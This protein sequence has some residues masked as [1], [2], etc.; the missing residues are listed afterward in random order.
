MLGSL[1]LPVL[2]CGFPRVLAPSLPG[3]RGSAIAKPIMNISFLSHPVRLHS[4]Y[5]Q[6][7]FLGRKTQDIVYIFF[8]HIEYCFA[9]P[10]A[11][12]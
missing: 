7:R 2:C 10:I 3:T 4:T 12:Y 1:Y 5:C 8:F 9:F 6:P 11:F